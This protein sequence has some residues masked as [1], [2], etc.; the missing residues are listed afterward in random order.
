MQTNPYAPPS[1]ASSP[2]ALD[3]RGPSPLAAPL[4]QGPRVAGGL[5]LV[6]ALLVIAEFASAVAKT[7]HVPGGG[8]SI[9]FDLF[10]GVSLLTGSRRH[11][12]WAILR[13]TLGVVIGM[14]MSIGA[15][16]YFEAG[17]KLVVGGT[18]LALLVGEASKLRIT[19]A[20]CAFGIYAAAEV[21]GLAILHAQ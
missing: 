9:A 7:S 15:A 4:S 16:S 17:F 21:I 13:S 14:A 20:C 6:N 19:L 5:L 18:V 11:L 3:E 10:I 1:A 8:V 2:S 12:K